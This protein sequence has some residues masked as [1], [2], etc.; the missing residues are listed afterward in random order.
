MSSVLEL[1]REDLR[2]FSGY[3]SARTETLQGDV[4]LNANE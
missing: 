3:K 4:W 1:V 2:D